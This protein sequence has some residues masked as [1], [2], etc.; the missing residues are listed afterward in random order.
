MSEE[1]P[2]NFLLLRSNPGSCREGVRALLL[3]LM[4]LLPLGRSAA[5]ASIVTHLIAQGWESAAKAVRSR[6]R[7][8][9]R[10]KVVVWLLS[11]LA[12]LIHASLVSVSNEV[13]D[14]AATSMSLWLSTLMNTSQATLYKDRVS[15]KDHVSRLLLQHQ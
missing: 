13:C 15:N 6:L 8:F 14:I 7:S 10:E 2:S 1:P 11:V 9:C 4:L 3:L 12:S 5:K